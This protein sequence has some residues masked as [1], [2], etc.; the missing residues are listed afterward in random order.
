MNTLDYFWSESNDSAKRA[1]IENDEDE[2]PPT[3][4]EVGYDWY[5]VLARLTDFTNVKYSTL[6]K[7][8]SEEEG[9][10]KSSLYSFEKVYNLSCRPK[11]KISFRHV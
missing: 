11:E 6:P 9:N 7:Y 3:A 5:C 10:S 8:I 1:I 2:E 4:M